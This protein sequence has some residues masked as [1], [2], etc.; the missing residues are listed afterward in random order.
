M[1]W[2][3]TRYG[4]PTRPV[5]CT[6]DSEFANPKAKSYRN[7]VYPIRK[8]FRGYT[9]QGRRDLFLAANGSF[10]I[11]GAVGRPRAGIVRAGNEIRSR[12][13][14]AMGPRYDAADRNEE[15]LGETGAHA[16]SQPGQNRN[17]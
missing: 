1:K 8:M 16:E 2:S 5:L 9:D 4:M 6:R 15:T 14:M 17:R 10:I 13:D 12:V 11:S 3:Y 7:P